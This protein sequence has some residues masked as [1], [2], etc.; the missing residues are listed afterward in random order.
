MQID[1][2]KPEFPLGY[3]RVSTDRQDLSV[4]A[5]TATIQ[6]AAEYHCH[7]EAEIIS[8]PAVSGSKPFLERAGAQALI[9]RCQQITAAGE[10]PVVIVP[11]VDRLGRDTVD[12]SNSARLFER[13]GVRLIFLDINVDTRMPMGRAFMQIAAVFAELEL[14]R[15]RERIQ[16]ALDQKRSNGQCTGTVPYGWNA[17]LTGETVKRGKDFVAIR[18]LEP[19]PEEQKWIRQMYHWRLTGWS[20]AKI[21]KELN[22]RKVPTKNPGTDYKLKGVTRRSTDQWRDAK[23]HKLLHSR[24]VTEWLATQGEQ[25]LAA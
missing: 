10:A 6:R 23:V 12:V 18:R 14:A 20:Y 13:L 8:D 5:Q 7:R 25:Q 1:F 17:V 11:K 22:A 19:N 2:S 15:I 21:A 24:T 9:A 4:E 3:V 16:T